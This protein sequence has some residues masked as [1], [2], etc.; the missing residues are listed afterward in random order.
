MTYGLQLF[1]RMQGEAKTNTNEGVS[2]SPNKSSK[3][4]VLS[5]IKLSRGEAD[6]TL[7]E[8]SGTPEERNGG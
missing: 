3:E 8:G 2:F 4:K 7:R 5:I 6:E 1:Y